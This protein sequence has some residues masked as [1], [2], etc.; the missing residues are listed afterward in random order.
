MNRLRAA[1][2]VPLVLH[3][4]SGVSDDGLRAAV[5]AGLVKINVGTQLNIAYTK[6]VRAGLQEGAAGATRPDPRPWLAD[7]RAEMTAA[8]VRLIGVVSGTA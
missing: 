3:G 8:A 1:V 7:A 5:G 6:A 4:S 2:P